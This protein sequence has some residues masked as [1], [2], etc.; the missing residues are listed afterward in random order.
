QTD[1]SELE[2]VICVRVVNDSKIE[3]LSKLDDGAEVIDFPNSYDS[4][5]KRTVHLILSSFILRIFVVLLTF[6]D[7][8]LIITELIVTD[9]T[10]GI[11]SYFSDILNSLDAVVIVVTLLVDIVCIFYDFKVV[12]DIPRLAILFQLL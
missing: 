9:N 1:S 3:Q 4:V 12:K 2:K 5:I 6:V 10:I 11:P 8:S 7:L